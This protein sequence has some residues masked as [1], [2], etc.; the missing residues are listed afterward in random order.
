MMAVTIYHLAELPQRQAEK[1]PNKTIIK[2]YDRESKQWR[3]INWSKFAAGV[4]NA[5]K[6]LAE[7]GLEPGERIGIYSPNMVHC[8]YTELGAFAMRGVVVPLY[9]T[10]SPEQLR[11]IV[12]DSSMETLFVGEQFQYNNAYRVQKEY[13]TLKRIVVFDER[14]VLNPEDKTSKY[15]SEFVR[16]GDS[17]PNETKVKVSSREAIP[18]D[19]AL[20]IYTSG[21]SGRSKGVLLLHS[22]LM[23]QMKVHS[24]HIPVY[25]PGELSIAFLP[26]SHIF[27]KAWTLFCLTTGTRI[28]ILRDPKKVLEALPQIRPSLMCNVPRFWE[29]VY[30]GVNEKMASSP[31]ILKGVY[32]RAMAVG[33]RY[34]LDYW[35]EGKRAPL[36]LSLQ[37]AFYNCT[38]FT[39]LKRVLGLQRGRYF[40]TAGAP[41]SDEINIFL[42][43]VNIPIIVGYG[44]SETTATVS[45]YPQRGFKIGSMGKVMPGLD[46]RIDPD[47]NEILVKGESVMSEYYNLPEETAGAFTPDGYFRTGDAGRMDPDGTLYFL[48]RIKDLYKTANG[49]YIAPQMIEGMLTKDPIIEQIAVIGD[50]F[51]YVSALVYPNWELVRQAAIKRGLEQARTMAV[52]EMAA[53]PEINRLM[54]ARI[55]AAQDSLAAYEKVKY[56]TLLAEPFT[57]EKGELTE[58]MKLKRRVINEHY[59]EAIEKMYL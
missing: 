28:A 44:L 7:I 35:N 20:I 37:Y 2:Y 1:S 19:P 23:Y 52:D 9:T 6:A 3:N 34:R 18:S 26:M 29:K 4:M 22:N 5:A 31:R 39:L 33:Q 11:F 32:R 38:I 30:Q 16:L 47:N 43:S 45:F 48:E 40:P 12:E 53:N 27:E 10:S 24:E 14:V 42:Q 8:L 54:M 41:L 21:T 36:L 57:L 58:T 17:M 15:F 56:I 55:E 51:K 50:R 59:A 25:G 46:A 13:G 49:K